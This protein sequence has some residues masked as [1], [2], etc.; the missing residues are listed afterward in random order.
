VRRNRPAVHK[1]QRFYELSPPLLTWFV[2]VLLPCWL[3]GGFFLLTDSGERLPV[4]R[5]WSDQLRNRTAQALLLIPAGALLLFSAAAWTHLDLILVPLA[6]VAFMAS[7]ALSFRRQAMQ[8][9][10]S[11][12][13]QDSKRAPQYVELSHVHPDFATAVAK[14]YR[15]DAGAS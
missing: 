12:R 14:R 11:R 8:P 15:D 1:Y 4:S 5:A 10:Y 3:V 13:Y 2:I 6:A 7:L 9:R